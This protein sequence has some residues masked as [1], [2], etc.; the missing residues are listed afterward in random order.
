MATSVPVP[1]LPDRIFGEETGKIQ[2]KVDREL[3]TI[4]S[5]RFLRRQDRSPLEP[6]PKLSGR[7]APARVTACMT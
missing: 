7:T 3:M 4:E 2:E 1:P 5:T 6:E